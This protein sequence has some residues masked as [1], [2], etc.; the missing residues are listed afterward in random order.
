VC[1]VVNN[2]HH[3]SSI[4]D[5]LEEE[6]PE[7][8]A[9]YY[10]DFGNRDNY[11]RDCL[12]SLI[13]QFGLRSKAVH[14]LL[15]EFHRKHG[16]LQSRADET[17][18]LQCLQYILGSSED[19]C[20]VLDALDEWPDSPMAGPDRRQ[21]AVPSLLGMLRSLG[22]NGTRLLLT[23]RPEQDIREFMAPELPIELNL[24]DAQEHLQTIKE[25]VEAEFSRLG[26]GFRDWTV[27]LK[28]EVSEYLIEK[29]NGM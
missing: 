9:F 13:F 22:A 14:D 1:T 8:L 15:V 10:F 6:S 27:E 28:Q 21:R 12:A 3:S 20:I 4:I 19:I 17:I 18:L 23:S 7:L 11:A 5:G 16:L 2:F 25:F 29:S 26:S 24:N